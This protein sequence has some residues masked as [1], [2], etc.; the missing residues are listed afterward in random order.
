[1][2]LFW[3]VVLEKAFESPLDCK[4]IKLVH[5]KGNQSWMLIGRTEAE[6]PVL[7]PPNTKSWLISKHPDAGKDWRQKEKGEIEDEM[8]SNTNSMDMS[9][10]KLGELVKD[11]EAR[12]AAVHGTRKNRTRLSDWTTLIH[13]L[14]SDVI[15]SAKAPIPK[16]V[17][18]WDSGGCGFL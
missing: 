14:S 7:W 2:F 12:C 9:L 13:M 6:A 16:K 8:E 5:P 18:F 4:E 11:S 15:V 10:N 3:T 17:T 1:M